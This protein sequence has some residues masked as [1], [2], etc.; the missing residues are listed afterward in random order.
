VFQDGSNSLRRV[1]GEDK[2]LR[3][4]VPAR[5]AAALLVEGGEEDGVGP[6]AG[7]G[8]EEV[9][10]RLVEL[11]ETAVLCYERCELV[12]CA[13]CGNDDG[14]ERGG[15]GD[16]QGKETHRRGRR[17]CNVAA[18]GRRVRRVCVGRARAEATVMI[19]AVRLLTSRR[20]FTTLTTVHS[21]SQ[22][23]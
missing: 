19:A 18:H 13:V 7:G 16:E 6:G 12:V 14:Q 8:R 5:V 23:I 3:E 9:V 2:G 4:S 20:C 17:E 21:P 10:G 1:S 11:D 22:T 15:D